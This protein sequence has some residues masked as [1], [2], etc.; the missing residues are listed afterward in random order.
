ML[1]DQQ[2]NCFGRRL[3]NV[4]LCFDVSEL[5]LIRFSLVHF[6]QTGL[7]PFSFRLM[8]WPKFEEANLPQRPYG[9]RGM[10]YQGF[11]P[12]WVL[13]SRHIRKFAFSLE[14]AS[15]KKGKLYCQDTET[16][17]SENL[18]S[19][20][21]ESFRYIQRETCNIINRKYCTH[22]YS[23]NNISIFTI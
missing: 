2:C 23:H 11:K 5:Y 8:G 4:R 17:Y 3:K 6:Q 12:L 15:T 16:P 22:K 7:L 18:T 19:W 13:L 9:G 20:G 1:F 10:F 14:S 21:R